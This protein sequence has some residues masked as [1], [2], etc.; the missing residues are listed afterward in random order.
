VARPWKNRFDDTDQVWKAR[1]EGAAQVWKDRAK[2]VLVLKPSGTLKPSS[3][4]VYDAGEFGGS[5][6]QRVDE[7]FVDYLARSSWLRLGALTPE[8]EKAI[9]RTEAWR[10]KFIDSDRRLQA[11]EVSDTI[12]SKCSRGSLRWSDEQLKDLPA[13]SSQ[14]P[15]TYQ[16]NLVTDEELRSLLVRGLQVPRELLDYPITDPLEL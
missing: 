10:F 11:R 4:P 9:E 15:R 2:G 13:R 3:C 8:E 1:V 7:G 14:S 5:Y 12:G 6:L 16:D